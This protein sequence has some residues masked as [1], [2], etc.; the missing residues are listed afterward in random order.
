M[1]PRLKLR[2]VATPLVMAGTLWATGTLASALGAGHGPIV[3]RGG[4]QTPPPCSPDG[5]CVPRPQTFG[6]YQ[7][8]WRT[9]PGDLAAIPPTPAEDPAQRQQR[10]LGGPQPPAPSEESQAGPTPTPRTGAGAEGAP[11]A[12]GAAPEDAA[13]AGLGTLPG[14]APLPGFDLP[15]VGPPLPGVDGAPAGEGAAPGAAPNG[16]Q[17]DPGAVPG[18]NPLDPFGPSSASPPTPPAWITAAAQR[19]ALEPSEFDSLPVVE[20]AV[21]IDPSTGLPSP[22]L[23]AEKPATAIVPAPVHPP[24]QV[25]TPP[26]EIIMP[27]AAGANLHSDDAPPALPPALMNRVAPASAIAPAP[28]TPPT[29]QQP[30]SVEPIV[31]V[32]DQVE[33]ASM[34]EP[35][36]I[37]LINP[38]AAVVDPTAEGL[39]QAIYFEAS[40]Q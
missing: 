15:G 9:F 24:V 6:F 30:P 1:S 18:G 14:E 39:Q 34:E 36:G 40:D 37:Q 27:V 22:V 35:L 7:T 32:D 8:R 5:A 13:E 19:A 12:E 21:A 25:E 11:A 26:A 38:A 16:A 23:P 28:T 31:V 3:N 29:V 4:A 20:H 10:E 17:P 33:A 2:T